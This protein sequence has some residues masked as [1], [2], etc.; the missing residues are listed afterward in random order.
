MKT[1]KPKILLWDLETSFITA[2]TF[3]LWPNHIPHDNI[4]SEA[5]VICGAWKWLGKEKV[6]GKATYDDNDEHVLK[7]LHQ[8]ISKADV[9][10][11]HNGDKF[12]MKMFNMRL[13][14]HG[15]DPL[16]PVLQ[17]DTLKAAKKHF[18]FTCN[19]LDY[20]GKFLDCGGKQETSKGLWLKAL[21]KDRKAIKEM[22][23]YNKRDVELLEEVYL[24]LRPFMTNHPNYNVLV[25]SDV[26][27]CP[28]CGSINLHKHG[29][30]TTRVAARQRYRCHDCGAHCTDTNTVYSASRR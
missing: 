24:K 1:R 30:R 12:D 5:H 25:E 29:R 14:K 23:E 3:S 13:I 28:N 15:M 18:R 19:R 10:V 27:L 21:Q 22:L 4:L 17:V 7:A 16:P 11:G 6:Y 8:A 20:L 26:P 9:I 2:A